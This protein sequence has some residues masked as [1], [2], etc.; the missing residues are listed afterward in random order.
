V[1]GTWLRTFQR[2]GLQFLVCITLED[3]GTT[4][5]ENA[6]SHLLATQCHIT[7]DLNLRV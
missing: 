7:E 4:V 3:E 6:E 2:I 1:L 5:P